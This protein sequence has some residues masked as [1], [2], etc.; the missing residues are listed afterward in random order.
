M[1]I[2]HLVVHSSCVFDAPSTMLLSDLLAGGKALNHS[3]SLRLG[4]FQLFS[5]MFLDFFARPVQNHFL[6]DSCGSF[7]LTHSAMDFWKKITT[8]NTQVV[9]RQISM[10]DESHRK[11][12]VAIEF[13]PA[14]LEVEL[15]ESGFL[16]SLSWCFMRF[17]DVSWPFLTY[18]SNATMT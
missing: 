16:L 15:I 14:T 13:M 9:H 17:H 8:S 11:A 5:N 3:N 18:A 10:I 4:R 1:A 7:A 12:V 6:F 2:S